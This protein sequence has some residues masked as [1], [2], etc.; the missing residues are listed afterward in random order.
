MSPQQMKN[1]LEAME[2]QEK[3]I[4]D[5]INARRAK[6]QPKSTDKDW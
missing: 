5:K 6:G 4:Q 3:E 2:N 1:L